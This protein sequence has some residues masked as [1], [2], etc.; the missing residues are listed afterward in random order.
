MVDVFDLIMLSIASYVERI[1]FFIQTSLLIGS[2]ST[3]AI[4]MIFLGNM[5]H[6]IPHG[7]NYYFFFI[8]LHLFWVGFVFGVHCNAISDASYL[9]LHIF[10]DITPSLPL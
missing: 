9:Y 6:D 7:G 4:L 10:I 8:Q 2:L 5:H 3:G 1:P